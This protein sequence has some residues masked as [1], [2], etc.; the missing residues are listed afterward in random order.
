MAKTS[1]EVKAILEQFT[2]P[3]F[4]LD[5]RFPLLPGK[6]DKKAE[7]ILLGLSEEELK[8]FR[9]NINQNA[10]QAALE[11]LKE[12][13][14]IDCMD[15]LPLDGSETIAV[16][17]DSITEDGQGWFEILKQVLEL[18]VEKADF[19]FINAGVGEQTSSE[20]LRRLDRDVL[21]HEPDWVF[22]ALGTYDAQRLNILPER[23]ITA[24]SESWENLESFQNIISEYVS[25][26]IIWITP[27][28]VISELFAENPLYEYSINEEDLQQVRQLVAGKD[29]VIIDSLG[30][31]MGK[32][33]PQAWNYIADGLHH[34]LAGHMNTARL[35]IKKLSESEVSVD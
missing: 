1:E 2:I 33:G 22:V 15:S 32:E 13:E 20:A 24:L 4:H 23:T 30:R 31:R 19:T 27:T 3:F 28:P 21:V 7:A 12:D 16:I 9:E 14:I 5:K 35:V 6:T 26:P 11:L 10:K 8:S 17:G 29:G 34:S 25:N 18:S